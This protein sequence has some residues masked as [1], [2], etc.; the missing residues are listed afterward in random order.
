MKITSIQSLKQYRISYSKAQ[1]DAWLFGKMVIIKLNIHYSEMYDDNSQYMYHPR[2]GHVGIVTMIVDMH[3]VQ[4]KF[5][6]DAHYVFPIIQAFFLRDIN[7]LT[8]EVVLSRDQMLQKYGKTEYAIATTVLGNGGRK[9]NKKKALLAAYKSIFV[10]H[11][12]TYLGC[13]PTF[14]NYIIDQFEEEQTERFKQRVQDLMLP[15]ME[16]KQILKDLWEV[17]QNAP[18]LFKK[19]V[20]LDCGYT[21]AAFFRKMRPKDSIYPPTLSNA[22]RESILKQGKHV[23]KDIVN[24]IN[25]YDNSGN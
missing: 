12:I 20:C 21:E 15:D 14:P 22:E 3:Y 23:L 4:V 8:T 24:C 17:F 11:Y 25:K 10:Y 5:E 1:L 9:G 18:L 2:M 7:S 19:Y 6:D 13:P 16:E